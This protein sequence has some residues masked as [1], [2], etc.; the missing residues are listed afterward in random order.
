MAATQVDLVSEA[1]ESP[2]PDTAPDTPFL[3]D[4]SKEL[5]GSE[6][7]DTMM[8][9]DDLAEDRDPAATP[10]E[11]LA[12]DRDPAATPVEVP[13]VADGAA[14]TKDDNAVVQPDQQQQPQQPA[15]QP[16]QQHVQ[17]AQ[18]PAQQHVQ[19]A[20]QPF[21]QHMQLVP[22]TPVS[23]IGNSSD[24][25]STSSMARPKNI[26]V[27]SADCIGIGFDQLV[28]MIMICLKCKYP[29]DE[30][31][32]ARCWGKKNGDVQWIC[33]V[34]NNIYSMVKKRL[35]MDCLEEAGLQL[36]LVNG[37]TAVAFY[38]H[39]REVLGDNVN[40]QDLKKLIIQDLLQRKIR[41]DSLQ[42][43]L[44]QLPLSVW[45]TRG[46][47]IEAIKKG[48]RKFAHPDFGE[49]WSTPLKTHCIENVTLA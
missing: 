31:H 29:I 2:A 6:T 40:W 4:V 17:P 11:V 45:A 24:A 35:D 30:K 1:S 13:S 43:S 26:T 12:E 46:F 16:A 36:H 41:R 44:E 38:K 47:D 22:D 27:S 15:Q 42:V 3:Q 21:Q 19:P 32:R 14:D 20:Q 9:E 28:N 5:E 25:G 39:A 7:K 8:Y 49:V 23:D 34:C 18:Q 37:D 48:G 33:R 10:V